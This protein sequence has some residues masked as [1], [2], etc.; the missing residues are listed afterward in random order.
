[1]KITVL[2]SFFFCTLSLTAQETVSFINQSS[3]LG[4]I[5]GFNFND[6]AVDMNGD[7]LDDV[8]RVTNNNMYIDY[9][10]PN[11]TF[12]HQQF[13][14]NL[15]NEPDWSICA[16]DLD[17]NGFNDLLFGGG[18]AV[19]F[20]M[21]NNDGTAYIEKPMSDFIFSQRST[22]ADI[23]NDGDLDAFV[24]HDIGQSHPYR[25]DGNGNMTL[26]Q[27]LINTYDRP[28]N[29]AAIWVDY[30]N[31]G[32]TDLYITK[33]KGG[34]AP[35]DVDRTNL[36][37]RNNG[38]GTF[39]EVGQEAG[40]ADNAQSWSTV[41]EDFDNDGD[42]DAFVVN[43][44]FKN[45]LYRNNGDGTFT[46]VIEQ[47]GIDPNDLGAWE[48][49]SGDFNNDGYMDIL[50]ELENGLYLGKGDLTFKGQFVAFGPGGIADLNN[51][52][53]LDVVRQSNL[54][55]NTGN[56]N[57]WL[58]IN[59]KGFAS[60][61][62]GI[63]A[64]VEI[65][66]AW[67]RQIR[68]VRSGQSFAPM[69]SLQVH[70][71]IGQATEID[72]VVVKW[73]SG[74]ITVVDN[75]PINS[76]IDALEISCLLPPSD[77]IANGPTDICPGSAL[78]L[79]APAGFAYSW[80]NG[81]TTQTISVTEAG[82]Y[83]AILTDTAG[84]VS[85]ANN[86]IV[87]LIEETPPTIAAEG[88]GLF[89]E[90]TSI[91][92]TATASD[93]ITWSNGMTGPNITVSETST[94]TASIDAQCSQDPLTSEEITVTEVLATTPIVTG[95]TII[96]GQSAEIT[97]TGDSLEWYDQPFG[98]TLLGTG[99]TLNTGSLDASATYYVESHYVYYGEIQDGGKPDNSGGGG[100]S[101]QSYYNFFDAWEPFTIKSVKVYVPS[102]SQAGSHTIQLVTSNSQILDQK[103]VN[104]SMG[105]HVVE[106]DFSVP[107]GSD[108]SLRSPE[109]KL[110][111][112]NSGVQYPYPI[113]DVGEIT[114]SVIGNGTYF[115]FYDWKVRKP[116]L[117]C[118]SERVPVTIEVTDAD[119]AFSQAGFSIFPNPASDNLFVKM[120]SSA[121]HLSLLDGQGR[122]IF[123]KA[124]TGNTTESLKIN[125]LASGMYV[126]RVLAKGEVYHTMFVK[127]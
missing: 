75:P 126:L 5:S 59:T 61:K 10:Q 58:K 99:N 121:E 94:L 21:A 112:N 70:F 79:T 91:T 71:G 47:S 35:G 40:L 49:G 66:G 95:T 86:V 84:C 3:L 87:H 46:D 36:L 41:F 18:N 93:S 85:I 13:S 53:F 34:A 54:L 67:G 26:D 96:Q 64:R 57:N 114:T 8:V 15:I 25:N 80:S 120:V 9:Q 97:A 106:L 69:G 50:A 52:G 68:E 77:I 62:N 101:S 125:E 110:F 38:D 90:G 1:M 88:L 63:G 103:I 33:C 24:C 122:L 102:S 17:G 123:E 56:D 7:F 27:S 118:V 105:E 48:N 124:T 39:S 55:I 111:R 98:G 82:T 11:G 16:G 37:Y 22:M 100:I 117:D 72:K 76:T 109:H 43:H 44:D 74:A 12:I 108:F 65:Y 6:C 89:C 78:E 2:I 20:V 14:I 60:N 83:N 116:E 31:D 30:D 42:F 107:Q 19:S 73:P 28:G 81:D 32:N 115:Y 45:R 127:E 4:G 92:L 113:G 104:L 119:E 23:D 29:Y 51:D